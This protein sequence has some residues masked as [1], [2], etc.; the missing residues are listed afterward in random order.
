MFAFSR[1]DRAVAGVGAV[2]VVVLAVAVAAFG[3]TRNPEAWAIPLVRRATSELER[4]PSRGPIAVEA[5]GFWTV[6]L[7]AGQS[8][9]LQLDVRGF[10]VGLNGRDHSGGPL[11]PHRQLPSDGSVAAIMFW[12]DPGVSPPPPQVEKLVVLPVD[13]VENG[14]QVVAGI[15][16]APAGTLAAKPFF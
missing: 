15:G 4:R 10:R 7:I 3:R 2:V 9:T 12:G 1:A 13:L 5:Y 8:L 16:L 14:R 6:P 11:G